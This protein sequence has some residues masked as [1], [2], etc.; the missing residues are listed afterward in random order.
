[1]NNLKFNIIYDVILCFWTLLLD[2]FEKEESLFVVQCIWWLASIVQFTEIRTYY[3][4]Y[5]IFPS[6]YIKKT[7]VTPL[8]RRSVE[9]SSVRESGIP[10]W[11]ITTD[12]TEHSPD[13][14]VAIYS[15]REKLLPGFRSN[16]PV[17]NLNHSRRIFWNQNLSNM[18]LEA[19]LGKPSTKQREQ[20]LTYITAGQLEYWGWL[21]LR[22]N[23]AHNSELHFYQGDKEAVWKT[24]GK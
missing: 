15:S 13:P 16:K 14:A 9:G 5:R 8:L 7:M 12:I 19:R 2:C 1:M 20:T 18:E 22:S 23:I 4:L 10:S 21:P 24:S 11:D 17:I 3:L 6:D